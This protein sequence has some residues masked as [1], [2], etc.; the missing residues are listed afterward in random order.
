MVWQILHDQNAVGPVLKLQTMWLALPPPR[1]LRPG[2][3]RA[4]C[5][6]MR[7][8]V[9][10]IRAHT[11]MQFAAPVV[12]G[13]PAQSQPLLNWKLKEFAAH[14]RDSDPKDLRNDTDPP[15]VVPAIPGYPDLHEE[16]APR[17]AA[18]S[19]KAR[20]DD[21][22]LIVPAAQRARYEAAFSRFASVFPD[23]FYVTRTRP[24]FPRRLRG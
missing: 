15:P 21:A 18:L 20:A 14:R 11:A 7:D 3:L 2:A 6:E 12:K 23:T 16:A 5:V 13:L 1:R 22:D 8:F 10:K 24:L 19:A 17:W 9:V 4:K